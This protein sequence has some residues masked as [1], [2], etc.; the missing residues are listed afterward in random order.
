[1]PKLVAALLGIQ[2]WISIV[3]CVGEPVSPPRPAPATSSSRF[4][5]DHGSGFYCENAVAGTTV[6]ELAS[7][8]VADGTGLVLAT[9]CYDEGE[10]GTDDDEVFDKLTVFVPRPPTLTGDWTVLGWQDCRIFYSWGGSAWP[11]G[12]AHGRATGGEVRLRREGQAIRVVAELTMT[13]QGHME[14][15]FSYALRI[16]SLLQRKLVSDLL[17]WE[18]RE[19]DHVYAETYPP[20]EWKAR[21][22][23]VRFEELSRP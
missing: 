19:G 22:P 14:D 5:F 4:E 11:D 1:M 8:R 3:G 17:A 16:E 13:V 23:R 12:A 21:A 9:R 6:P 10:W 20:D 2:A 7:H 18:G 15:E